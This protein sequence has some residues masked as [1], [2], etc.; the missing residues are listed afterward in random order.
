MS[1]AP[2]NVSGR[3]TEFLPRDNRQ[4]IVHECSGSGPRDFQ[5]IR[6]SIT[7]RNQKG[8]PSFGKNTR[9]L[10]LSVPLILV[11]TKFDKHES[12]EATAYT[13]CE[14][15]RRSLLGNVRH[16]LVSIFRDLI[17]NL[18]TT[19]DEVINAHSREMQPQQ[20]LVTLAW[21]VSQR[22]SHDINVQAAIERVTS[23]LLLNFGLWNSDDFAGQMLA[24]CVA[25]IHTDIVGVWNLPDKDRYLSSSVFKEGISYLVQD[26]SGSKADPT[27]GTGAAW[28]NNRYENS[29]E[30]I[31]L[32]VGYIVDLT[33]ILCRVFRSSGNVSLNEVQSAMN[34][35]ADTRLKASIHTEIGRF[36]RTVPR[37]NYHDNDVVMEKIIDLIR[38]NCGKP[39]S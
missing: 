8:P 12:D 34:D 16:E 19:T 10:E 9:H 21:S 24:D 31:C 25:V 14:E 38:Q 37:F 5:A 32:V 22:A 23:F 1:G 39:F 33:L 27:P 11:F 7:T 18:V 3:T 28:L 4:L 15:H 17:E 36:I 6:D 13:K 20:S 26:L 30:N 2:I 35:F 29:N